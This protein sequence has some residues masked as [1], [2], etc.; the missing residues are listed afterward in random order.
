MDER[1]DAELNDE[2]LARLSVRR[3]GPGLGRLLG[4]CA[5]LAV[6]FG[7]VVLLEGP[8]RWASLAVLAVVQMGF[9]GLLHESCHGTVFASGRANNAA[10][11]LAGFVQL[12]T[13]AWMRSFH[14]THHRT[15]HQLG[16]PELGGLEDLMGPW[17]GWGIYLANATG[18]PILLGRVAFLVGAATSLP[19]VWTQL[20]P[21]VTERQRPAVTRQAW[22]LIA[23]HAA[24]IALGTRFPALWLW[25]AGV[26]L[27]HAPLSIYLLCE[28]RGLSMEAPVLGKTRSFGGN[29][30]LNWLMWNMPF[31]AEHHAYPSVPFHALPALS[32][33]LGD[34]VVHR[35]G[36][37]GAVHRRRGLA[38]ST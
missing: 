10:C 7:G 37:V 38:A 16:D 26:A 5:L 36:T 3:D 11:W 18:L 6:S 28:H 12:A 23:A 14:F 1:F 34:A 30:Q 24:F 29:P 8:A 32:G 25:Y 35:A 27:A 13:P 15:T 4:Q 2:V 19:P 21:Y 9:F 31:H 20:L 17:P 33:E 22:G